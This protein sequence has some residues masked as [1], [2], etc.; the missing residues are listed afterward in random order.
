MDIGLLLIRLVIGLTLAAHGAQKLFG[1]FGGH[2]LAGTGGF[3]EK[4]GFHPGRLQAALAGGAEFFGGLALAAGLATPVAAAVI[5]AVMIVAAAAA[6][7]GKGFFLQGG[8]YE[9]NLVL[10]G[11]ALALAYTGPGALSVDS[12]FGLAMS[13]WGFGTAALAVGVAGAMGS[14]VMRSSPSPVIPNTP[15][16]AS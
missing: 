10:A 3:F 12:A 7:L 8:G 16:E 2:G 5:V 6:H 11:T 1:W 4:L 15:K 13:G 14:L 9:Y